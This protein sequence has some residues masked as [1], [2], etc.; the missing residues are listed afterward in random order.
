MS[1]GRYG[2]QAVSPLNPTD[3]RPT[4]EGDLY[5]DDESGYLDVMS[6]LALVG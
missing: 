3:K 6:C 1:G 5:I 4:S 2:S